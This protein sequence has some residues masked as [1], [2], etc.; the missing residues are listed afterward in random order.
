MRDATDA[1]KK[2]EEDVWKVEEENKA[3]KKRIEML[4]AQTAPSAC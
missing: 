2:A 3:L 4:T 1:R